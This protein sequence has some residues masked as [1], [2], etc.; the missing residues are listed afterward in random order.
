MLKLAHIINPVNI[1][2]KSDLYIAQPITFESLCQ[3]KDYAK[4]E[5]EV[6]LLTAQYP[7]D[8]E[9]IPDFFARTKNLD[10]SILDFGEFQRPRKLPLIKDIL[11]RM[12]E[13]TPD[14]EYYIYTNVDIGVA[15]HFYSSVA[16][17]I[18]QGHDAFIINRRTI[19]DAFTS[20]EQLPLMFAQTGKKHPGFDCFVFSRSIMQKLF[21][22]KI[23]IGVAWIGKAFLI[24]LLWHAEKFE[25]FR[26]LHCTFHI[27]DD[28][29]WKKNDLND[30]YEYNRKELR[31]I[32]ET[33]EK[34]NTKGIRNLDKIQEIRSLTSKII[35]PNLQNK[36]SFMTKLK[37]I[38][39]K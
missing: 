13:E 34:E 16:A 20:K 26:D 22:S 1:G 35:Y 5:V 37:G 33:I 21:L 14:A 12:H 8:H 11:D 17:L 27:G 9:I 25:I 24:N 3:A 15:P 23:C 31:V 4:G 6:N 38:I 32:V 28:Q 2:P 10:R 30:Y 29:V 39:K 36:H 7:E 19:S 18:E